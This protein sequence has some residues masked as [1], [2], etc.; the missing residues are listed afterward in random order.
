M[1]LD[2]A[3][4]WELYL[5]NVI[6]A[7]LSTVDVVH[8]ARDLDA[9]RYLLTGTSGRLVQQLRPDILLRDPFSG[10]VLGVIDAKYK[11]TTPSPEK[12]WGVARED[13]YQMSAYLSAMG[14]PD[15][16]VP[17]FLIYP[18]GRDWRGPDT[19]ENPWS[20]MSNTNRTLSFIGVPTDSTVRETGWTLG[21][22][23][24]LAS[25]QGVM[26]RR[27]IWQQPDKIKSTL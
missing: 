15:E 24:M 12:P 14:K 11:N 23:Q 18:S 27:P 26:H 7:G 8:S 19:N 13:L 17:G 21:E 4:I 5:L 2:M 10:Q 3:E 20:L 6:R 9:R 25:V 22:Q 1:L 16:M